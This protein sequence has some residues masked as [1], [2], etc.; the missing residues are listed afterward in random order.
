MRNWNTSN[1]TNMN[2]MF[3]GAIFFNGE[4]DDWN[5]ENV[6][7]MSNMFNGAISFNQD[8]GVWETKNVEDM[9]NMF[10]GAVSFNKPLDFDMTNVQ[11]FDGMFDDATSFA[12]DIGHLEI[13]GDT[14]QL[15]NIVFFTFYEPLTTQT[16]YPA[17][18]TYL[19]TNQDDP[20]YGPISRWKTSQVTDMSGLFQDASEFNED[21]TRWNVTNV[22]NM[23]KMF[24]GARKFNQNISD[25]NVTN[26][27]NFTK[28]FSKS[29]KTLITGINAQKG[30]NFTH[31]S[32]FTVIMD[33]IVINN[34]NIYQEVK[35][36]IDNGT[37]S[38]A[39]NVYGQISQWDTSQITDMSGLFQDASGFNEDITGWDVTNVTDMRN[40][41]NGASVFNQP[42]ISGW[43]VTNV[44]NF[45]DMF[46]NSGMVGVTGN[47]SQNGNNFTY[48]SWFTVIMDQIVLNDTNIHQ[49]VEEYTTDPL[50]VEL[51][52]AYK[53]YGH[54]STWDT[55]R[56]TDMSEL[57]QYTIFFNEDITDWNVTN[58]TDMSE[59]FNNASAFN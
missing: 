39:Y 12:Q 24:N 2:G 15:S 11:I 51:T 23:N 48:G 56:V 50:T 55:S 10:K 47:H 8:I 52:N 44:T 32:W 46:S 37:S 7:N 34:D 36:Y 13:S 42:D 21:I 1:I 53:T 38:N 45:T 14:T 18:Q 9:G 16:I 20:S 49:L 17:V 35:D 28:M 59:M 31:G 29:G 6:E 54:I 22:T 3:D 58:V 27:T 30:N 25:W 57:F 19:S 33:Q 5:T 40:M 26:V 43:N 4:I 41:F